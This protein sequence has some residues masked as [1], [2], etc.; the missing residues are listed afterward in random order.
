MV[1]WY[2]LYSECCDDSFDGI[3]S[4]FDFVVDP[5]ACHDRQ[6]CFVFV[7]QRVEQAVYLSCV[8]VLITFEQEYHEVCDRVYLFV[9]EVS[10][11]YD[12]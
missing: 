7:E 2:T 4:V 9:C 3:P 11:V 6:I 8:V 10:V 1:Y 12:D 5:S